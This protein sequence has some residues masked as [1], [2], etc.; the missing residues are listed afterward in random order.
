MYISPNISIKDITIETSILDPST[1]QI[2]GSDILTKDRDELDEELQEE[3]SKNA[4]NHY[5]LW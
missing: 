2:G 4:S 3:A 1:G 5:S